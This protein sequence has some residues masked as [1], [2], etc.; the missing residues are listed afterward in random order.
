MDRAVRPGPAELSAEEAIGY[1]SGLLRLRRFAEAES[2]FRK[3]AAVDPGHD[4]SLYLLGVTMLMRV[5]SGAAFVTRS[6]AIH[7]DRAEAHYNLAISDTLSGRVGRAVSG[8]R[9]ALSLNPQNWEGHHNLANALSGLGKLEAAL[10]RYRNAFA[11]A[12]ECAEAYGNA[13]NALALLKRNGEALVSYRR[14]LVLDPGNPGFQSNLGHGL[15]KGGRFVEALRPLSWAV[16]AH[17]SFGAAY[18]NLGL[19]YVGLKKPD[20]ALRFLRRGLALEPGAR[21]VFVNFGNALMLKNLQDLGIVYYRRG[22]ALMPDDK[23]AHHTLIFD[24]DFAPGASLEDHQAER[25]RWYE[26]HA[27]CFAPVTSRYENTIDPDRKLRIGYVSADFRRHSAA[28]VF[29]GTILNHDRSQFETIAYSNVTIEDDMTA[30]FRNSVTFWRSIAGMS[31]EDLAAKIRSDAV[32]ILVDLSG[33]TEGNR[34]LAFA[35]KPAPIQVTAWGHVT[36]TGMKTMDYLFA[37]PV[38]VPVEARSLFAETIVDLP[39]FMSYTPPDY[40]P[41]EIP[42]ISTIGR[43][44]V[45]GCLNRIS[46]ISEAAID[47]WCRL[48]RDLPDSRLLLKDGKL[49]DPAERVRMEAAFARRG[50]PPARLI[51]RGL[52]SHTV[53]LATYGEVDISLDPFPQNGGTSSLEA[54][55]MGVPVVALLGHTLPGRASGALLAGAGF[56]EWVAET[57]EQYLDIA[58]ELARSPDL[59]NRLHKDLRGSIKASPVGDPV[60]YC[61][62]TE[63]AYREM[64][65]RYCQRA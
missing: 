41:D 45:F 35:R 12:P 25:R 19:A 2:L 43:P 56:R 4:E 3:I 24:L 61:R 55:W 32:D 40:V 29:G 46:K 5:A 49:S 28:Y 50:I 54:L 62:A 22:L 42:R 60:R 65:R 39:V 20:K 33:H 36:G 31:D 9:R 59:L 52:T 34:L 10:L 63:A 13:G 58:K 38:L 51:Q 57:P 16:R 8:Y 30:F 6:L 7:P 21:D 27:R 1:A 23:D 18:D 11:L 53:H 47:L 64:W 44:I 37:D 14:A 26:R 17:P 48:L 15:I